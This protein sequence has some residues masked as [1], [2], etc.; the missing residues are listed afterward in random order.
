MK[1]VLLLIILTL[2]VFG[3]KSDDT[4]NQDFETLIIGSWELVDWYDDIPRDINSDGVEST[5]LFDQWDACKKQSVMVL[6]ED[7]TGKLVYMGENNNP[8]CPPGFE[9]GDSF[10]LELWEI[11]EVAQTFTL[12]G[13]DYIDVYE[14]VE[15]TS[16]SLILEGAGFYTCCNAAISYYQGGYLRFE[17]Q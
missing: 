9:T 15:L 13:D 7:N 16:N 2:S 10:T 3:C 5:N 17:K 11:D 1:K 12:I 14:I 4:N 6:M 8:T